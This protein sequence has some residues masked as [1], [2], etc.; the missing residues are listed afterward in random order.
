VLD[1][2]LSAGYTLFKEQNKERNV[3]RIAGSAVAEHHGPAV[4]QRQ[5]RLTGQNHSLV[6]EHNRR[7]ILRALLSQGPT[8]RSHLTKLTG[9]QPATVSSLIGELIARQVIQEV[10]STATGGLGRPTIG[11]DFA[12]GGAYAVGV[13]IGVRRM[14]VGLVAPRGQISAM[15]AFPRPL[16]EDRTATLQL[17][18]EA[19]RDTLARAAVPLDRVV[20]I[21]IGMPALIDPYY[22]RVVLAVDIGWQD[23]PI[24]EP[25][26]TAFGVPIIVANN[27]QAMALAESWFGAGRDTDD[28]ALIYT[29]STVSAGLVINGQL[30]R[31]A[32]WG[33]GQIGHCRLPEAPPTRCSCGNSG[34]LETVL[35]Q[36]ALIQAA[37]Q[38]GFQF[39][40]ES[41]APGAAEGAPTDALIEAGHAGDSAAR[42]VLTRA[43]EHLGYAAANLINLCN[44]P[45]IVL[46]GHLALAG[47]Q[48]FGPLRRAAERS[49]LPT[50]VHNT[51][52]APSAFGVRDY[53]IGPAS[54]A[55]VDCFYAPEQLLQ[56][57]Q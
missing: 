27:A 43:G 14:A 4:S 48:I 18:V 25:F 16:H 51:R 39:P 17:A 35:A 2:L 34:C 26:Q 8:S 19:I 9:L 45:L 15:A 21:G 11:L 12:P 20:G 40:P 13:H 50:L 33:A 46:A 42:G 23:V 55:L 1:R 53:V 44:P 30:L 31:G 54:L 49:A 38:A 6:R 7:A 10:G 5:R 22:G 52:F 41:V 3:P 57:P 29:A 36:Q 56:R 37:E 47:E 24:V 28:L 32:G